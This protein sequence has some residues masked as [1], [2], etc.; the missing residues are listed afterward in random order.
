MLIFVNLNID[1]KDRQSEKDTII[2]Q[3]RQL[4]AINHDFD[5][6]GDF[7]GLMSKG[8]HSGTHLLSIQ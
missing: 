5:F 4:K 2:D 1:P 3:T 7:L 8:D 6:D